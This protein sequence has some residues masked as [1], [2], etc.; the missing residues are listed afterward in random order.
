MSESS[1]AAP[2]APSRRRRSHSSKTKP[3]PAG[4]MAVIRGRPFARL[5]F[6]AM[7]LV[8]AANTYNS[9]RQVEQ[10]GRRYG[11]VTLG[12]AIDDLG[13]TLG[14]ADSED[15]TAGRSRFIHDGRELLVTFDPASRRITGVV[16]RE[17]GVTSANCPRQIGIAPGSS[18]AT[19]LHEF[20]PA[21]DADDRQGTILSY[22]AIGTRF[23]LANETVSAISLSS[24][25][26]TGSLWPI[27][28]WRMLP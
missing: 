8:A 20:G 1:E 5:L 13:A 10:A 26:R 16:C 15:R 18:K 24:S 23:E 9:Y 19:V 21:A 3:E 4:P 17:Q 22:P 12:G 14:K 2:T 6:G 25:G 27:V 7:C 11:P 28:L